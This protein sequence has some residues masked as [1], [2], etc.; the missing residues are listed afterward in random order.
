MRKLL[1]FA[2]E[3]DVL[4]ATLDDA[5]G[6]AGLLIVSGATRSGLAHIVA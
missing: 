5:P 6:D 3:G 2:C 4:A 1:S